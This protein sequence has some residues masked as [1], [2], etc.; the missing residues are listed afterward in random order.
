[1]SA[2]WSGLQKAGY[3]DWT[4]YYTVT[5]EFLGATL[6]LLGIYTRYVS[7]RRPSFDDRGDAFLGCSQGFCF[8]DAGWEFPVAWSIMLIVQAPAD[9]AATVGYAI[10]ITSTPAS[11]A[12]CQ[13]EGIIATS[14]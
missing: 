10:S 14:R 1:M 3:P 7:P 4:L 13:H 11:R 2:W 9:D 6:L 12:G 5:T 8:T